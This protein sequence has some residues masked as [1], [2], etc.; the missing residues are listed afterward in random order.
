[1]D[2]KRCFEY[3]DLLQCNRCH[4][5]GHLKYDCTYQPICKICSLNH[6]IEECPTPED[7]PKCSNCIRENKRENSNRFNINH[8]VSDDRCAMKQNRIDSLKSF[9]SKN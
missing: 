4:R 5:Y 7:R 3:I 8:I 9:H 2:E 1:M 6:N